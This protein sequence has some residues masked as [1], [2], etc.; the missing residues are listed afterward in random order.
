MTILTPQELAAG[1]NVMKQCMAVKSGESVLIVTDPARL[2]LAGIFQEAA[3]EFTDKVKLVSFSTMT[4]NAQEPPLEI[5]NK[6]KQVNV[7]LLVTTF[8]LSHTQARKQA[9]ENGCR[10]ASMPG[11]TQDMIIRTLSA[12]YSKIAQ[13]STKLAQILTKADTARLTSPAGTDLTFTLTG[14]IGDA[15]TGLYTKP[16]IWGNLPAGE[17]CIGP[18]ERKTQ[19]TLIVDGAIGEIELDQPIK[20]IIKDGFA[21]SLTGGKTAAELNSQL[22]AVGPLAYQVAELGIGTN[23]LAKLSP[24]VLEAEK[25]YGTCHVALGNN[26]SYGGTIDVPFHDDGVILKPTLIIDDKIILKDG[27]YLI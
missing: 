5:A 14:R 6:M 15:D 18:L 25:V 19:G 16:G 21:V 1:R 2:N 11:I 3:K 22:Q 10:I 23:P 4:A 26:L 24:N 7:A 27:Q 13:L 20:I 17:A 8:S 9:T 12:D